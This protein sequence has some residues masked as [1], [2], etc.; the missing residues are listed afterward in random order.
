MTDPGPTRRLAA[1]LAADVEGYSRLMG[2]D[3]A[4]TLARFAAYRAV[5][6]GHVA[7]HQG[8]VVGGAGDSLLIEF[9]SAVNAVACAIAVQ[10]DLGR[11]NAELP[12]EARMAF[13]IGVNLGDIVVSGADIHGDG[14]NVAARIEKLSPAG[15]ICVSQSVHDQVEGKVPCRFRGLGEH[16]VKNIAKPI[17]VFQVD[18]PDAPSPSRPPVNEKASVAI[19]PFANMSGDPEQEYFSDGITE[20]IITELSRFHELLVTSRNSSFVFRGRNVDVKDAAAKLGVHYV[21]EGSVR[22]A[23]GRVRITAQL[24][25]AA[26]ANHVWAERYDRDLADIFEIQDEVAR[27]IATIVAG[28]VASAGAERAQR[29]PT[30]NLSAYDNYLRARDWMRG[31]EPGPKAEPF[32]LRA[33]ELDPRFALAHALLSSVNVIKFFLEANLEAKPGLLEIALAHGRKAIA[34]DREEAWCHYAMAHPLMFMNRLDDAGP[35]IER[36]VE[37]NPNDSFILM[38]RAMWLSYMGRSEDSLRE[39]DAVFR[40]DPFPLD[41]Y[42]DVY[43]GA[44]IAAGHYQRAIDAIKRMVDPPPW[45]D[46]YLAI[47]HV[48][49]GRLDEARARVAEYH[50]RNPSGTVESFFYAEPYRDPAVIARFRAALIAAG[51]PDGA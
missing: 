10:D 50:A 2:A 15:A 38:V 6:E 46:L 26:T 18:A 45:A 7:A 48:G 34:L 17:R 29:R 30:E 3:E 8:R 31:Y 14:V 47:C 21:V 39:M 43:S 22:K 25:D 23:G 19:L 1:I 28:R 4:A 11:R 35:H 44:L 24:I 49:L 36:A 41:W 42:W 5:I 51:M 13:R 27:T 9:G 37:L 16:A 40:R 32:L 33:I 12:A 20:D